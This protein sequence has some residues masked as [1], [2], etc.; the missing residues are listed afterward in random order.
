MASVGS[1]LPCSFGIDDI[2]QLHDAFV[3]STF[4]PVPLAGQFHVTID[5][6]DQMSDS[7]DNKTPQSFSNARSQGF[8]RFFI[9][10]KISALDYPV[11]LSQYPQTK[12]QNENNPD[13]E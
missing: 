6:G 13:V 7:A 5:I 11:A 4:R 3:V 12:R 1:C 10:E 9:L 2:A 8:S